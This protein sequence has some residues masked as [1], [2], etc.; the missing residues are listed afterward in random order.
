MDVP[1]AKHRFY[2]FF[3][4]WILRV[5]KIP[6]LRVDDECLVETSHN[7]TINFYWKIFQFRTSLLE[8]V[9]QACNIVVNDLPFIG[10]QVLNRQCILLEI[11]FYLL[12]FP[13]IVLEM[14]CQQMIIERLIF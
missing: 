2:D 4:S 9:F 1:P 5:K 7:S 12:L 8:F 11:L 3:A 14:T 6:C 10:L 13:I